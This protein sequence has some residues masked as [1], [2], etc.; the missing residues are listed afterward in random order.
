MQGR[1]SLA[2]LE[3]VADAAGADADEHLDEFGAADAE[4][5]HAGLAGHGRASSVLPVPGGADQQ[6][7][8]GHDGAEALELL[9]VLEELDD[10]LQ[11][12]LGVLHAGHVLEGDADACCLS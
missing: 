7:A 5:R 11:F 10:L 4:E 2:C 12:A 1:F 9:G 8:L 6:H 3:H